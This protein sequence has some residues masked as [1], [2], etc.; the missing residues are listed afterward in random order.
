MSQ[1]RRITMGLLALT[2][3]ALVVGYVGGGATRAESAV[4]AAV[5]P[6]KA[7][8]VR[9]VYFP[10]TENLAPDEMRVTACGTGMPNARPKQQNM[11]SEGC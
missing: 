6:V 10:G 2:G 5:S 8:E 4:E 1:Q 11:Y 9:D 7:L 3:F